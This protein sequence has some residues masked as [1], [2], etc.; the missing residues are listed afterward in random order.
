MVDVLG[1][2][3][4]DNGGENSSVGCKE[5]CRLASAAICKNR[6]VT[7]LVSR[8]T[9]IESKDKT[10]T[11]TTFLFLAIKVLRAAISSEMIGESSRKTSLERHKEQI[12]GIQNHLD[13]L[14][15]DRIE[16]IENRIEGLGQ[17][18]VIIQQDF[19]ALE[20]ELQQARAQITKFHRKQMGS[21]HKISL[22]RFRITELGDIIND[23][24]IRHQMDMENLQDAINELKN[25]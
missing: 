18:G 3:G 4:S 11:I 19:N 7:D 24:Q 14:S 15:L 23:I 22:A 6:G 12:E 21:N 2:F 20:A 1:S 5:N 10:L 17:G 25:N 13:K 9:V 8:A 16:Y